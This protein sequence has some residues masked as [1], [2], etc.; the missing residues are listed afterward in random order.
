[1]FGGVLSDKIGAQKSIVIVI[2][3]FALILFILPFTTVS[4][5]LFIP[6]MIV[7]AALSWGLAPPQQ[8]YRHIR[9]TAKL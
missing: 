2:T 4:I 1:M 8:S 5:S 3:L 6:V 7:W 9:Y